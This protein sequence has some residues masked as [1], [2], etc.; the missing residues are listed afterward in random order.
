MNRSSSVVQHP[1]DGSERGTGADPDA[2]R[3]SVSGIGEDVGFVIKVLGLSLGGLVS[4]ALLNL[5]VDPE[6]SYGTGWVRPLVWSARDEKRELLLGMAESPPTCLILG[7]SRTMKLEPDVIRTAV[8]GRVFN[9]SI[10]EAR[11]GDF[12]PTLDFVRRRL[13]AQIRWLIVGVDPTTFEQGKSDPFRVVSHTVNYHHAIMS[14]RSI[15]YAL[16]R[17]PESAI[18]FNKDGFLVYKKDDAD[19]QAGVFDLEAKLRDSI[20]WYVPRHG[21]DRGLSSQ[22]LDTFEVFV[23][24]VR[25][26]GIELAV[27]E[28]P[29]HPRMIEALRSRSH[30]PELH[31]ALTRELER[32]ASLYDFRMFDFSEIEAFGGRPDWFYDAI[33]PRIENNRLI[34]ARLLP[35]SPPHALQ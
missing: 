16:T 20:S 3:R 9:A 29:Y 27:Y 28:P 34:L 10:E 19:L 15:T 26:R 11:A 23:K 4:I 12:L 5:L 17:Y 30:Y 7:S 21:N 14:L 22:A 35:A 6:G 2:K 33:H 31:E 1:P 8:G 18:G 13:G 25:A 32:L 24:E